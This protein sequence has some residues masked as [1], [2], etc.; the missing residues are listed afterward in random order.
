[1]KYHA[2]QRCREADHPQDIIVTVQ[3]G[4]TMAHAA[5]CVDCYDDFSDRQIATI[6][7]ML[8]RRSLREE[9]HA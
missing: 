9:T 6:V 2:F 3:Y 7:G 1:M 5:V 8:L 4:T